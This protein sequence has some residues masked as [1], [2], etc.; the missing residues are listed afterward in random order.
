M[1]AQRCV[2]LTG[3]TGL[4]GQYLLHDLLLKGY[5]VAVLVRD[6]RKERAADRISQI[7]AFW[8]ERLQRRLPTPTVLNGDLGQAALGLT[9]ADR[10]WLGRHCR[11]VIHSAANLSF[12]KTP[13]GEPWRTNVDGTKS[14]LAL[15]REAGLLEWHQVSTAFVCGRRSGIIAE[16]DRD[17]SQGFHTPYE[18]SKCQ[19]EELVARPLGSRATIYRPAIIVGDSRTGHTS[20][21]NGLYRFLQ[22]AVRLASANSMNGRS[23]LAASLA[24]ERGRRLESRLRGLG[25]ASDRR[26]VGQAAVAR[27]HF[28]PGGPNACVHALHQGCWGGTVESPRSRICGLRTPRESQSAGTSVSRRHPGILAL[29]GRQ[30]GVHLREH[31][32]GL[33]RS[34]ASSHEPPRAGATDPLRRGQ[35]L[36]PH[37]AQP[38]RR[39]HD[40]LP[41]S[42][43]PSSSSKFFQPRRVG[44]DWRGKPGWTSRSGSNCGDPGAGNGPVHGAWESLRS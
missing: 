26:T 2:L 40:H 22:L 18:E 3:A 20:S 4:L 6:T 28:P 13:D 17:D 43:V 9:A 1:P 39:P 10:R 33:A 27:P 11:A 19:A 12:R 35:P 42:T 29:P 31:Q 30:P 14:L 15:C 7:V 41:A 8:S 37:R 44:P 34:A 38:P 16:E 21:F 25:F 36:G 32:R 23:A 24:A 5:A